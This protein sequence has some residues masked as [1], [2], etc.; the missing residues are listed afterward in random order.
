MVSPRTLVEGLVAGAAVIVDEGV[1]GHTVILSQ[2]VFSC[3]GGLIYQH[4]GLGE[5]WCPR[6]G[7]WPPSV[8]IRNKLSEEGFK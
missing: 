5:V 2:R 4:V 1:V 3:S 6:W 7:R 8:P